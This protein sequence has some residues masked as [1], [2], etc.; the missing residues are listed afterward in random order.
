MKRLTLS[1]KYTFMAALA[2]IALV[3]I[4]WMVLGSF[5]SYQEIFQ[6]ATSLNIHLLLPVEWT[7]QNYIDVIFDEQNPIFLFIGN[8]LFV[9]IIVTILVLFIN[10]MAAFAFAKLEFPFKN[11]IFVCFMSAMIIPGEVTLVPNYLLM[12]DL[13]WVNDYKALI[14]PSLVHV[15]G[16]FL[17]RQFF[18]E[19][20]K[21][22]IEAARLDGA[23]WFR[24]YWN[25][26][27]PSAVP[28]LITLGIITFLANWDAYF[29]PLIVINDEP[30]QLIQVAIANY[31]SLAGNEWAKIL[32]ANTISTI[33][34]IIAFLFLQKYYIRG[35]SMTGMK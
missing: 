17:L 13:G 16:I 4:L 32:A 9:T 28:A 8:T 12:N 31:S 5:R 22:M 6:Y 2:L 34:I 25:I 26:I 18:S 11:V 30:K 10:S 20:P 15:F 1:I 33:P 24:I 23:S 19:I 29:W 14:F 35:I 3:P 7:L 21:D 27:L